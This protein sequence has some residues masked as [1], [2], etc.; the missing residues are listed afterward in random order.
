[1]IQNLFWADKEKLVAAGVEG[2]NTF[3]FPHLIWL[4]ILIAGIALYTVV[5]RKGGER[6]RG[7]MRKSLAIFMI[8]WEIG[9]Q[10]VVSLTGAS[11]AVHLP[12]H[13]CSFAEY[14]ILAD[15]LWPENRFLKPV[16]C[17]AFLPAGIMAMLLPTATA[18]PP[19][20]FY[21]IH[22]FLLHAGIVAYILAR[23]VAREARMNY[24]GVWV[25]MLSIIA[26]IV[27]VYFID[28]AFDQNYIFLMDHSDNPAL[29]IVWDLSGGKG[30]FL[31]I[32]GLSVLVLIVFH[33]VY[34]VFALVQRAERRKK[35]A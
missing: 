14:A 30:G 34:A 18:Y 35:E 6:L 4:T 17:Y 31:Y 3:S 27:P 10:C 32:I 25:T 11:P 23:Y 8:L 5:Y 12:L 13:I 22:H 15:A 2:F 16:L 29:K 33:V 19:V 26:L 7:N 21:A 20:S 28:R 1:M 9:K 24:K